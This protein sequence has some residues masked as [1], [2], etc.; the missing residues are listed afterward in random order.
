MSAEAAEIPDAHDAPLGRLLTYRLVRLNALLSA[1]AAR[2]LKETAGI[3]VTQWRVM[4]VLDSGGSVPPA[5]IV[6]SIHIDKGQLSRTI[7]AMVAEGLIRSDA[8]GADLRSHLVS[9]T[10]KGRARFEA[11][12]PAMRGRRAHLAESMDAEERAILFK[13]FDRIEAASRELDLQG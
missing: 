9:L 2:I 13:A 11:A 3:S 8:S 1:Q 6:K 12:R 4:V 7:K 5:A 10:A